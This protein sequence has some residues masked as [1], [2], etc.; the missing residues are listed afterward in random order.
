LDEL[1]EFMEEEQEEEETEEE[2]QDVVESTFHNALYD[3]L[4][5]ADFTDNLRYALSQTESDAKMRRVKRKVPNSYT[6]NNV[7]EEDDNDDDEEEEEGHVWD[8]EL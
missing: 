2:E 5:Y 8:V 3:G 4:H 1:E 6:V 7:E